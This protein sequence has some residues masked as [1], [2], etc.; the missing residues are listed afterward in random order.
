MPTVINDIDLDTCTMADVVALSCRLHPVA[1]IAALD[2]LREE[3]LRFAARAGEGVAARNA[4]HM[5]R[6]CAEA[7]TRMAAEED[8]HE[9]PLDLITQV[10]STA[11]RLQGIPIKVQTAIALRL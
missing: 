8:A 5:A 10:F 6:L 2:L 11:A 4:R 3:D 9:W 1:F 7:T